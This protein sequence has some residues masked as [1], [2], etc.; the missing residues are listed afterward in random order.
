MKPAHPTPVPARPAHKG[1]LARVSDSLRV[2]VIELLSHSHEQLARLPVTD[3]RGLVQE[4]DTHQ[5]ELEQQNEELRLAQLHLAES[6]DRLSD[7]YEFAPIAY[8]TLDATAVARQCNLA[9]AELLGLPREKLLG[10]RFPHFV[11]QH[12]GDAFHLYFQQALLGERKT[13]CEF[14]MHKA[15]RS[16]SP[17]RLR[18]ES[19]R[20]RAADPVSGGPGCC[21]VALIDLTQ[22]ALDRA[23]L[24]EM[25]RGLEQAVAERTAALSESLARLRANEERLALALEVGG[26]GTWTLDLERRRAFCD[27]RHERLC[28]R[29]PNP[30][31][32]PLEVWRNSLHPE[33]RERM[34][35]LMRRAA[36]GL[37]AALAAEYRIVWADGSVHWLAVRGRVIFDKDRKPTHIVGVEQDIDERKTLEMEVLHIADREQRRIGQELHDDIQQRLTGLGLMAENLCEALSPESD[38]KSSRTSA[39]EHAI[40]RRLTQEIGEATRRVKRLSHG[41]VPLELEGDGLGVALHQLARATDVPGRLSCVFESVDG[42]ELRD[43]FAATHLYRIAQE[44][45]TNAIR[46]SGAS[47]I[48]ISLSRDSGQAIMRVADNGCGIQPGNGDGRGLRIMAYRASLIG[49][50]LTVT[51]AKSKGTQV[52]CAFTIAGGGGEPMNDEPRT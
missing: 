36:Q 52:S 19:T 2:R 23:R 7:L 8:L 17:L 24:S 37:D 21:H 13:T 20:I 15:D 49:A 44:A 45:V 27:E 48:R 5:V 4:L 18:L 34:E 9:A 35:A 30:D 25:N 50:T 51:R 39:S 32:H 6:R 47:R 46:H 33:D 11:A 10:R 42:L 38:P 12:E 26:M 3:I 16:R 43:G 31:G 40:C 29:Q 28:G 22:Q 41:L 14:A 1:L